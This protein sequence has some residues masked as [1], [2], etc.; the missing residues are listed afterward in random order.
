SL[1][2]GLLAP[3][4]R[5]AFSPDGSSL[6][7]GENNERRLRGKWE[8]VSGPGV[9]TWSLR[10]RQPRRLLPSLDAGTEALGYSADG[11]RLAAGATGGRV[12]IWDAATGNR[13]PSLAGAV[14]ELNALFFTPDGNVLV[15]ASGPRN[16]R[17]QVDRWGVVQLWD[18]RTG[19]LLG[20]R[21][22]A[23]GNPSVRK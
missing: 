2:T 15:T 21:P 6:A 13:G 23:A 19:R 14:R 10:D 7:A 4:S 18:T 11:Q 22:G 3:P 17:P 5:L 1:L 12:L 20:T 16:L 9:V 8:P